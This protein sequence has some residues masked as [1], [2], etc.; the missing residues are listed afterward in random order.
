[1]LIFKVRLSAV[2]HLEEEEEKEE[3]EEEEE[4]ECSREPAHSENASRGRRG[5]LQGFARKLF[6]GGSEKRE[7][8]S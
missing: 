7:P 8:L 1:M 4:G 5:F 3:E 2:K 6:V